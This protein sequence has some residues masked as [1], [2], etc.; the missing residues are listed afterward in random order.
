MDMVDD[1]DRKGNEKDEKGGSASGEASPGATPAKAEDT[2]PDRPG[3]HLLPFAKPYNEYF[4]AVREAHRSLHD[5]AVETYTTYV[6]AAQDAVQ[7]RDAEALRSATEKYN[8]AWAELAKP[9]PLAQSVS[10]AF[11]VYHKAMMDAF[12]SGATGVLGPGCIAVVAHSMA[13]VACHR[14]AYQRGLRGL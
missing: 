14:M 2:P 5:K 10:D 7:A 9:G 13:V 1:A 12:A 6:K 4:V 3:S 8:T 11:D